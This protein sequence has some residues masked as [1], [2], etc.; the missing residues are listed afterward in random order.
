MRDLNVIEINSVSRGA[1]GYYSNEV[2][3]ENVAQVFRPIGWAAADYP[4]TTSGSNPADSSPVPKPS[5]PGP[6]L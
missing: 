5:V 2:S 4:G 3:E 6:E 1:Y